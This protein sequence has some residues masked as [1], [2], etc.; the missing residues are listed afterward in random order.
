[1]KTG[2]GCQE[3][4]KQK[5]SYVCFFAMC[6][7]H[8]VSDGKRSFGARSGRQPVPQ[9]SEMRISARRGEHA[10]EWHERLHNP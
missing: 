3:K 8:P 10:T 6:G 1:M 4:K 2:A 5:K 9:D 7:N